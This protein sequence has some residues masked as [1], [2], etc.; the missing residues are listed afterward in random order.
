MQPSW[1]RAECLV[2][3]HGWWSWGAFLVGA[4]SA[5]GIFVVLSLVVYS[6]LKLRARRAQQAFVKFDDQSGKLA[7]DLLKASVIQP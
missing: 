3:S 7:P 1:L 4:A 6:L 5:T 2:T